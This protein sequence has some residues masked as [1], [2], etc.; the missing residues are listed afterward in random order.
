MPLRIS[1]LLSHWQ[2]LQV[3]WIICDDQGNP[4]PL[5][6]PPPPHPS[7]CGS[8]DWMPYNKHVEF[9]VANFLYHR[10]QM[11]MGDIDFMFNLWAAS[12][13]AHGD[14]LPFT[15]HTDMYDTINSTSLGGVPWQSFSLQY[16]RILP[17][18]SDD[19][20]S[21]M[22]S[23]YDIWFQDPWLL[24]HNIILNLDFKDKFDYALVQEYSVSDGAHQFHDFMSGNWCW[25]QADLIVQDLDTIG[26]MFIPII[27]GSDKTTVSV[28]TGHNQYWPV[29]MSIG[30][31][32]NNVWHAH[33]NGIV[34]LGFLAIL[35]TMYS[36]L[37]FRHWLLHSSLTK[38]LETLKPGMTKPE[39]VHCPDGH[40]QQAVYGLGPY[41][42]DYPKQALLACIVQNW[43]PNLNE[44][45][46]G[47][48]SHTHTEVLVE[49]FKLGVLWDE[50]CLLIKG[51]FK[52][53][54]VQ[55]V[56]DYIEAQYTEANMNRI[57]DDIDHQ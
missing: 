6:A 15:N 53:H 55:W 9:E 49:E 5:D 19:V 34:L 8:D 13:A 16:N 37:I 31:I 46:Y 17:D 32:H 33:C 2:T 3:A 38:M 42:A 52:D 25:K 18:D 7:D 57:L 22:K 24:V 14:T 44:G 29:Y 50:Y 20:P 35:K 36:I 12:L 51:A 40:F 45:M 28:T 21:W 1:I 47:Q 27:L 54:L 48:C 41:I 4:I 10:N 39:V 43:C 30:N 26:S 56:H 23:E 11:S